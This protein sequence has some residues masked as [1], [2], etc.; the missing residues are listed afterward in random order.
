MIFLRRRTGSTWRGLSGG[1]NTPTPPGRPSIGAVA[2]SSSAAEVSWRPP[3]S[4]GSTITGYRV[5]VQP[6]GA[7]H[8]YAAAVRSATIGG[9]TN[10]IAYTFTVAATNAVGVG[11]ESRPS[12][13]V[14]PQAQALVRRTPT[15]TG[16]LGIFDAEL[17][18]KLTYDDLA[19]HTGSPTLQAGST[20]YRRRFPFGLR[21]QPGAP[22]TLDQCLVQGNPDVDLYT[23]SRGSGTG[24]AQAVLL[25]TEIDG[26]GYDY[27]EGVTNGDA[28]SALIQ[29]G[30]PYAATRCRFRRGRDLLK[31]EGNPAGTSILV[32]D[33]LLDHPVF[34]Y[35]AH[36]DVLQIA[37]T[38]AHD[39]TVRR[40][41]LD[42]YRPDIGKYA[43]SSLIQWGS[44]PKAA[45]GAPTAVLR[46][47]LI[48]DLIVDGGDR[49]SRVSAGGA[50]I[51]QNVTIR[52]IRIGLHH[53][54]A[55]LTVNNLAADGGR[56]VVED[57][58]WEVSG[59]TDYGA[60]VLAGQEIR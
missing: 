53:Q 25:D 39:V 31:P 4:G 41:T 14:T 26:Q 49:A 5:T 30:I 50:A 52:R 12:V 35:L 37:G 44:F 43:S 29:P 6:G 32:E 11:A 36:A 46:D 56:P 24:I 18:R 1:P 7:T 20:H 40:S 22:V 38:G 23:L 21:L 42:G 57:W 10:G 16:P 9:L 15:N 13:P 17:G 27:I 47:I 51:C 28:P 54:F 45:D 33:S 8:N 19:L 2:P 55:P 58:T 34:P 3:L 48:E 60:V 59:T